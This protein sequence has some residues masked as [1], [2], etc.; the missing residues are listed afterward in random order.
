[1]K[2]EERFSLV[3]L[4][5]AVMSLTGCFLAVTGFDLS[6]MRIT[7]LGLLSGI[8][9]VIT[10]SFMT[11]YMRRLLVHYRVW[12][13]TFYSIGFATLFWII[14][15][16]PWE[17][18]P[19]VPDTDTWRSLVALA[20]VSVLVPNVLFAGGL[21]FLVPSRVVITSTLEPVVAIATAAFFIGEA[22]TPVQGVGAALVI[23]AIM[24]LQV[25]RESGALPPADETEGR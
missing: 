19:R 6:T 12:T 2:K 22:I 23:L 5:A 7:R 4:L 24:V 14:L 8:G 10:F 17:M 25:R 20:L 3:K 9:S 11:I 16:P 18:I 1:L 13:V 15:L 21:R